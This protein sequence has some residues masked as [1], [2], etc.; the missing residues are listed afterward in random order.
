MTTTRDARALLVWIDFLRA[1]Q[2]LTDLM[3]AELRRERGMSLGWYG[4]LLNLSDATDGR[5]RLQ[6]LAARLIHSRSGLT[7]RL[8]SM[9][10]AGLVRR[11]P[12][13]GDRRG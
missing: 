11:E 2:A 1:H 4:V 9:E 7:R 8:D 5:L 3:E 6:E 10:K 13:P 12:V